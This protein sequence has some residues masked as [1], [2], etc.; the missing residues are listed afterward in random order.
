MCTGLTSTRPT[1]SNTNNA[2]SSSV[3]A[4][5]MLSRAYHAK[6]EGGEERFL[7]VTS[8]DCLVITVSFSSSHANDLRTQLQQS[9]K[10]ASDHFGSE[11]T[12][13]RAQFLLL[14]S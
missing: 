8:R 14:I 4:R 13:I 3:H 7:Q 1:H 11:Q 12:K 5:N 10:I 9:T 2:I 6:E